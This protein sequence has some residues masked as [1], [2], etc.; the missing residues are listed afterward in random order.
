MNNT[1][2]VIGTPCTINF[3]TDSH[4]GTVVSVSPSGKTIT[5][6]EN[7]VKPGPRAAEIG[8]GHQEWIISDELIEGEKTYRLRKDGTYR[9]AGGGRPLTIGTRRNY[10]DWS[11]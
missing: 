9:A 3:Y 11:F 2:P 6:R 10:H 1:T 7:V 5:V 4:P 8:M